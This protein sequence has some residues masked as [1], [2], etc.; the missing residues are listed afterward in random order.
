[1][2]YYFKLILTNIFDC[3]LD[4]RLAAGWPGSSGGIRLHSV[5]I[6]WWVIDVNR[7]L[8]A[9]RPR[10]GGVCRADTNQQFILGISSIWTPRRNINGTFVWMYFPSTVVTLPSYNSTMVVMLQA[11]LIC[12]RDLPDNHNLLK[13]ISEIMLRYDRNTIYQNGTSLTRKI[14]MVLMKI[15]FSY[16]VTTFKIR[17]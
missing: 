13:T 3:C 16:L 10:Q 12:G 4:R 7:T 2:T 15:F 9:S 5:I 6:S 17:Q 11:I 8:P 14:I 1:M